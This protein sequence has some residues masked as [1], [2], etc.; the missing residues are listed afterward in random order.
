MRTV[1]IIL[2]VLCGMNTELFGQYHTKN[3]KAIKYFEKSTQL[4]RTRNYSEAVDY[5]KMAIERDPNFAEAHLRLGT[6]YLT[7]GDMAQAR[8]YLEQA[9]R[10]IPND[11]KTVGAYLAL[12]E[13]SFQAG[14]YQQ[15]LDYLQEFSKF[16]PPGVQRQRAQQLYSSA[17]FAI[18]Q[19]ANPLPFEPQ[20]LSDQV[21]EYHL[22]Y[23]PVLTADQQTLIFTRRR[24]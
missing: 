19:T 18:E 6:N 15:T 21:N 5:L 13:M 9:V 4:L 23:F 24:L 12:S 2:L 16:N 20:P 8:G 22:Q 10:I 14:E 7:L 3:R 11:P 17:Q 1:C